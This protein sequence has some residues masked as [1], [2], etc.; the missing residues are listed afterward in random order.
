MIYEKK[1]NVCYSETGVDG[2]LKP[3]S[4]LNYLQDITS[5]HTDEMG[6]SALDLLPKNLAWVVFKYQINIFKYP[7]WKDELLIRTWRY[8]VKNLYELRQ[9]EIIDNT[10][11]LLISS[12]SLWIL[13]SLTT[14]KPVRLQ[15]NLPLEIIKNKQKVITND[16]TTLPELTNPDLIR[17]FTIRMHDLDFNRHVNNS[18]YLVWGIESVPEKIITTHRPKEITINY[19]S[20]SVYGD[21]I[22]SKT[23]KLD[24]NPSATF[25]HS[26]INEHLQKEITRIK[27]VWELY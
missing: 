25:M 7:L 14:K 5:E 22:T 15:N 1:I 8:P 24:S 9:F 27:T 23:Q 3:V 4:V 2:K 13:T 10:G 21:R 12:K 19:L 18:V 6:V 16:L 20:D 26:I 17:P 11:N